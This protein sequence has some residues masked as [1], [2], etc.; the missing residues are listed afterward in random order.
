VK[1]QDYLWELPGYVDPKELEIAHTKSTD[2]RGNYLYTT[3]GDTIEALGNSNIPF[4]KAMGRKASLDKEIGTYYVKFDSDGNAK[5][6]LTCVQQDDH[7]VHHKLNHTSTVTSRLS[8]S[9]PNM[10]N[11]PRKDKS[12]VKQVFTSRFL[13]DYCIAHGIPVTR[14][15]HGNAVGMGVMGELDYSQLEVVVQGF[16]CGDEALIADL[17]NRVDFHCKRVAIR[18][19]CTY[20][21]AVEW[22]KNEDSIKYAVWSVF[23]TECKIF[24]FQRAYGAGASTIALTAGMKVDDVKDMIKKEDAMYPGVVRFNSEVEKEVNA[25]AEVF[26]DPERG[27]RAFR[28]GT[29]QGPTGT[30]YSWRS[31]D[32]PAFM[33]EKGITDTFSPP[34]MKNYPTQG[35]GGEFVQMTLGALWRWFMRNKN[36]G[37][38][39]LLCNTVHDCVWVDMHHSVVD[40][41]IPGMKMI[42]EGIPQMLKHH[43]GIDC[44]VPFP[45]DAE[46]GS[47]MHTMHHWEKAA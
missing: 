34:E 22:C 33:R 40:I 29:W 45:V 7:I 16:L 11:I 30:M 19:G 10:Q 8:A 35:T 28:R 39:A 17:N 43:Y 5:G 23:R 31:W 24:S 36:F 21:E 14:D 3:D 42:M 38:L 37:G 32:A 9:D 1:F 26:R 2:G 6:M 20:E 12:K 47:D 13:E 46:V 15:K 27:Y 25:T 18:E 44:P 4:L 41:V